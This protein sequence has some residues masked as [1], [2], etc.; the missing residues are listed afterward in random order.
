MMRLVNDRLDGRVLHLAHPATTKTIFSLIDEP[1]DRLRRLWRG[2][3]AEGGS[4]TCVRPNDVQRV[5][6][7]IISCIVARIEWSRLVV[8]IARLWHATATSSSGSRSSS[9]ATCSSHRLLKLTPLLFEVLA[10]AHFF[11]LILF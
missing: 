3:A 4:M 8:L 11:A 9:S 10:K 6:I 1:T 2:R 5:M 7:L